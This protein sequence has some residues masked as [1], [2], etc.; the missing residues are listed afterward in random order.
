MRFSLI[1]GIWVYVA[2]HETS[3]WRNVLLQKALLRAK[4]EELSD[5]PGAE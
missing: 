4:S 1:H 2:Q 5:L 3:L